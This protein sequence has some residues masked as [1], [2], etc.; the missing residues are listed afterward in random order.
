MDA[1]DTI[2]DTVRADV[3][4]QLRDS[5]DRSIMDDFYDE[6]SAYRPGEEEEFDVDEGGYFEKYVS[7]VRSPHETVC[8]QLA[9]VEAVLDYQETLAWTRGA[10]ACRLNGMRQH[11]QL[12][13]TFLEDIQ[14]LTRY[15]GGDDPRDDI[16]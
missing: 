12:R 7:T 6:D 3:A 13:L 16:V 5:M 9:A 8:E 2:Y 4:K 14:F 15:L 1:T 10:I 11:P